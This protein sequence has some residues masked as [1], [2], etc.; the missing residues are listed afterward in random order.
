LLTRLFAH[1]GTKYLHFARA[2]YMCVCVRT[3]ARVCVYVCE[4]TSFVGQ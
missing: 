2:V 3:R 1:F 4:G